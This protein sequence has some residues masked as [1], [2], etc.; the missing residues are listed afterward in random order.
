[1]P[2]DLRIEEELRASGYSPVAGVDEAGRGPLAGPVAAAAVILPEG[3]EHDVI[4]DSK[5]LSDARRE[6]LYAEITANEAITWNVAL[7]S[8]DEI[9]ELNI[10][11][12][13]HLAMK[14]AVLGLKTAPAMVII[15]GRDVR[16]FP[17]PQRGVVGGDDKSLSIAAASILAK[18]E[19]DRLMRE[20]HDQYPEYGFDSHKGYGTRQHLDRLRQYGP[21][22]IHRKTF[23][24]VA[25]LSLDFDKADA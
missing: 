12:A 16:N 7:S 3:F 1:M 14:R 11:G 10:L 20:Y 19:R 25:Q 13:T 23:G 9:T 17:L 21:C 4:R 8:I 15:D 22:P 24:P 6:R 18:V 5:K 2:C